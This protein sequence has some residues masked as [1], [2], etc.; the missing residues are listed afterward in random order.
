MFVTADKNIE[1]QQNRGKFKTPRYILSTTSW[2]KLQDKV[3]DIIKEIIA[4]CPSR[5]TIDRISVD[6]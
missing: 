6:E 5:D 2:P 3:D 4:L 1:H